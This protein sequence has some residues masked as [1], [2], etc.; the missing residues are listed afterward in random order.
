MYH[1]KIDRLLIDIKA[2]NLSERE[3]LKYLIAN[4]C[5]LAFAM[6]DLLKN[7]IALDGWFALGFAILQM[8]I[9]FIG[10]KI[11][12]KNYRHER[13]FIENVTLL[14]WPLT[15]RV[16]AYMFPIMIGMGIVVEQ[17]LLNDFNTAIMYNIF[18]S[19]IGI[20]F[21]YMLNHW[22]KRLN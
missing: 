15:I 8:A 4:N 2:N 20:I 16:I 9:T 12:F 14:S 5:L 19:M 3:K 21:P 11:V 6:S 7:N 10:F 1:W 17:K 18:Y 13:N 22:F